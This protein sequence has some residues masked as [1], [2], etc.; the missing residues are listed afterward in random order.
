MVGIDKVNDFVVKFANVNG[1]GSASANLLFTKSIFRMGLYVSPKN[2]FPSNIQ[3]LPTWY[4]VRVNDKGY[5]GRRDGVDLMVAVN[6]Q[7]LLADI[8]EIKPGGY[9]L[10]DNSKMLYADYIREDVNYIGVPLMEMCNKEFSDPRQRLLFK[11][12]MYV[13]ALTALLDIEF[14]VMESLISE[15]FAGKEKLIAPN[16]KALQLG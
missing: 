9:L 4:E 16:I 2:F 11:N 8:K 1:T 15:Q 5:I 7:S 13:G 12:I 6:A 10:Y 14:S 3:G